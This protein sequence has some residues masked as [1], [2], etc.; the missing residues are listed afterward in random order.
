MSISD[1][2]RTSP[3]TPDDL[4]PPIKP[5]S[6][7]YIVQLFVVPGLIVAGIAV[8]W[9]LV[10]SLVLGQTTDPRTLI[11]GLEKGGVTRWQ[12]AHELANVLRDPRHDAVKS[13]PAMAKLLG[14][15]LE[16]RLKQAISIMIR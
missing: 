13:D 2:T 3:T 7:G 12:T 8:C 4:L 15:V 10:N 14:E 1:D 5:P 11:Q 6:G 16:H 9:L